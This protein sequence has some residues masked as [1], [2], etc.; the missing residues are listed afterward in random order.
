MKSPGND[1]ML[2]CILLLMLAGGCAP[3]HQ[4]QDTSRAAQ[5]TPPPGWVSRR[6]MSSIYYTGIAMVT[7]R[8][9]EDNYRRAKQLAMEDLASEISVEVRSTSTYYTSEIDRQR[10]DEEWQSL[11]RTKSLE[12]LQDFEPVDSWENGNELWVYYRLSRADYKDW[13][14]QE[15]NKALDRAQEWMLMAS[16]SLEGGRLHEVFTYYG[17]ARTELLPF[18]D[19]SRPGLSVMEVESSA[20]RLAG[21]LKLEARSLSTGPVWPGEPVSVEISGTWQNKPVE[22]LKLRLK[23]YQGYKR[24]VFPQDGLI[25]TGAGSSGVQMQYDLGEYAIA[26]PGLKD[27]PTL[28]QVRF[29]AEEASIYLDF[30]RGNSE[31]VK[32]STA[33]GPGLEQAGFTL[34]D[35][36]Y[37]AQWIGALKMEWRQNEQYGMYSVW[38]RPVVEIKAA[39]SGQV[40]KVW[41]LKE[42]KGVHTSLS[43]ARRLALKEVENQIKNEIYTALPEKG[44]GSGG[45]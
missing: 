43:E 33:M 32:L 25:R 39:A 11:V 5:H 29:Q 36:R 30:Y 40:K 28:Q 10:F 19:A 41:E 4:A 23:D 34:T 16:R 6:P 35:S 13:K 27:L 2:L 12:R 24:Y 42:S 21:D 17:K 18:P 26:L 7:K 45:Y 20:L 9:G 1:I 8:S 31:L 15:K 44:Y 37:N 14:E 22:G 3:Q 38:C